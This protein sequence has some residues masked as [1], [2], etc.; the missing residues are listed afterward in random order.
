MK[1]TNKTKWSTDDLRAIISAALK[2]RGVPSTGLVVEVV[3]SKQ[4]ITG[5]ARIGRMLPKLSPNTPA[6][7]RYGKWMVLR[8]PNPAH[9][10]P[11]HWDHI[12]T[13]EGRAHIAG[14]RFLRF[15]R[16]VEHEVAHLQGLTHPMM[17]EALYNCTQEVPWLEGLELRA[18]P[19]EICDKAAARA[20]RL[21]HARAML[22]KACTREKRAITGRKKWE[23]R[24]R[25]LERTGGES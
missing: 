19:E 2:V 9:F 23:R 7:M 25:A 21:G 6:V 14:K 13:E 15:A 20:D 3:P 4:W 22:K 24:V 17:S 10:V 8:L 12:E 5:R 1:I 11:K 16:V 18:A